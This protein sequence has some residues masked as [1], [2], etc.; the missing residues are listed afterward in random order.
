MIAHVTAALTDT[1][2]TLVRRLSATDIL[3]AYGDT[4]ERWRRTNV[5]SIART[6]YVIRVQGRTYFFAG[7]MPKNSAAVRLGRRG[8]RATSA[9]KTAAAQANGRKGGRPRKGVSH[10]KNTP[11][12]QA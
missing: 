10:G 6:S 3:L 8:G 12:D 9:A 4:L 5:P 2:Y 11:S 7:Q 1:P